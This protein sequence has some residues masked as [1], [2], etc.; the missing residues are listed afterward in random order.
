MGYTKIYITAA[1]VIV[2]FAYLWRA[3][4]LRRLARYVAETRDELRKCSWPS[5]DELKGST[6]VVM[7]S[8]VLLGG[9]TVVVDWAV[10]LLVGV[11]MGGSST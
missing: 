8:I 11:L 2:V 1:V 6:I 7:I 4:H 3:G 5:R 9:Y 10:R